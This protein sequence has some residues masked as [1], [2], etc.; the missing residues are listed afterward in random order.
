MLL[1][2]LWLTLQAST[3]AVPLLEEA[4]GDFEAEEF[5]QVTC[6]V[7]RFYAWRASLQ[8]PRTL[9]WMYFAGCSVMLYAASS[10]TL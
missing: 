9:R 3:V 2:L 1:W 7:L 5:T 6:A 10:H 8:Q 4:H